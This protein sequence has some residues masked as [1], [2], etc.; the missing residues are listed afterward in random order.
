MDLFTNSWVCQ[1]VNRKSPA[2]LCECWR[3]WRS[4]PDHRGRPT[5]DKIRS[6]PSACPS[7]RT[8]RWQEPDR[9]RELRSKRRSDLP[10]TDTQI[11]SVCPVSES[12]SEYRSCRMDAQ[13][14]PRDLVRPSS[15]LKELAQTMRMYQSSSRCT[16]SH[17]LAIIHRVIKSG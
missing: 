1:T 11:Q 3:F 17:S 14:L 15:G 7:L 10:S 6:E 5:A 2:C 12:T 8:T 13:H 16:I 4:C 9:L